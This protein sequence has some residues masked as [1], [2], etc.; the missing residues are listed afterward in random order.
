ME[1]SLEA[2]QVVRGAARVGD[3]LPTLLCLPL[4][5]PRVPEHPGTRAGEHSYGQNTCRTPLGH[6]IRNTSSPSV[7]LVFTEILNIVDLLG[8]PT[9][10]IVTVGPAYGC[11]VY[12]YE[13]TDCC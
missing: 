5:E 11:Y 13:P 3:N 9:V 1:V 10:V 4:N 12:C 8:Q 6:E 7:G 2:A